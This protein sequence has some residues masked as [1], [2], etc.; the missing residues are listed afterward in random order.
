MLHPRLSKKR[1]VI[2]A[3]GT[4]LAAKFADDLAQL[5]GGAAVGAG[6]A[7][8]VGMDAAGI[9]LALQKGREAKLRPGDEIEVEFGRRGAVPLKSRSLPSG[10]CPI[11]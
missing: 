2:Q 10:R 8:L 11:H 7:R 5:A 4:A 3:G 9:F 1:L 6:S